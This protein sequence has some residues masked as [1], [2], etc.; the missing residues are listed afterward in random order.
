MSI[1]D[2]A[3]AQ[4]LE[5]IHSKKC[6]P[7]IGEGASIRC[8][9]EGTSWLPFGRELAKKWAE[10]YD[11]PLDDSSQLARVAQFL[12][13]EDGMEL[14]P[15]NKLSMMLKGIKP[16]DFSL[17][18]NRETPYAV[19][20]DLNLPIYITTN[21]DHFMET[22]LKNKGKDPVSEFCR[23]NDS[24]RK[25]AKEAGIPSV[26]DKPG[27]YKP[28]VDKPLVYHLHGDIYNPQSMVLTEKDYID[29]VIDLNREGEQSLPVVVRQALATSS[30]LFI[31]YSL[32]DTSFR[33]IFQGVISLQDPVY[34]QISIA[35]QL[36]PSFSAEKKERAQRY[37]DNYTNNMF[38]VHVYWGDICKFARE[39]HKRWDDFKVSEGM[40]SKMGRSLN[41]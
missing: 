32:E 17:E 3:W 7:F 40:K 30:L 23:W 18:E 20:A 35:V 29:F 24:L 31:G 2:Y 19:L 16:P 25:Y 22:A 28:T 11:Y 27:K 4:M 21:Y 5:F 10:E 9:N 8:I 12:A 26:F 14:S 15:K 6:I 39:I 1:K 38:K 37:L 41:T 13:I 33:V 34:R 36:H